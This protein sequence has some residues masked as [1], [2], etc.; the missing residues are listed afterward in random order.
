MG[1]HAFCAILDCAVEY[2]AKATPMPRI[3]IALLTSL[4][5]AAFAC[6]ES[7]RETPPPSKVDSESAPGISEKD[8]IGDG[9]VYFDLNRNGLRDRNEG[10]VANAIVFFEDGKFSRADAR[11]FYEMDIPE[12]GGI[13]WVRGQDDLDPG[14][15]WI[16]AES[17]T[18]E[19]LDIGVRRVTGSGEFSFVVGSD[20][21]AGIAEMSPADQL[22]GL[23]Q[24]A[25]VD[26]KP[27]FV[28]ITG[29]ITQSNQPEHFDTVIEAAAT[30]DVPYVP[31]PGNHDWYDGGAAYRSHFGPPT[32]S[33]DSGGMH[34][35]VLNDASSLTRRMSFLAMDL[36]L[37][38]DQRKVAVLMHAPPT[39]ELRLALEEHEIDL[40]LTGHLHANRVFQHDT[41]VE[42]NTQPLVMG[43]I[44]LSPAGFRHFRMSEAGELSIESRTTVNRGVFSFVSPG[45]AQVFA[46]CSAKVVVAVEPG[47]AISR[48][49]ATVGDLG[50]VLLD[51]AG[52]WDYSSATLETLCTFGDYQ[53]TATVEHAD[54]TAESIGATLTIGAA[55]STA[56]GGEWLMFQGGAGHTGSVAP[57]L[58]TPLQ[59]EWV[60]TVGAHIHGGSP[61]VSNNRVFISVSD[62]GDGLMGGVVALDLLS[63]AIL[64]EHRVAFSVRN[65]PAVSANRVFFVSNDGTLHAVDVLTGNSLWTYE[66]ATH[67]PAAQRSLYCAP[68][69]VDGIVYVGGRHEFVAIDALS[70]E[71]V[72]T[73]EP[74]SDFEVFSSHASA[75]VTDLAVLIPFNRRDGLFAF[76]RALGTQLWHAPSY[77]VQGAHA[78]PV[79]DGDQIYV[80]NELTQVRALGIDDFQ[81]RWSM[82]LEE[83]T[84]GWGYL[85]V[86]TPVLQGT[87]LLVG[88]Q[89]GTLHAIDTASRTVMWSFDVDTSFVRATHYHGESAAIS[90]SPVVTGDIVWLPGQDGFLRALDLVTGAELWSSDLG[91]PMSSS[92]AVAGDLLIVASYDGS[93]RAMRTAIAE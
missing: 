1:K 67:V 7:D 42:Y 77:L 25:G 21:H 34:F 5:F 33:F 53:V 36:A 85:A 62:F 71:L 76:D 10:G 50:L 41:F 23:A 44:D 9:I 13:L 49:S 3:G 22:V 81:T 75:V 83:G 17:G 70:G 61:V 84:F 68:T 51:H 6:G 86:A 32:Y 74:M 59:T 39:E 64:W 89:R 93:V 37:I 56:V 52:G 47:R 30:I 87:T 60:A 20:T 72:W 16:E 46:P 2:L 63:G 19:R 92:P 26:P 91:V 35:V 40:L 88:T 66:L 55:G 4:A 27:Y 65:A 90:A 11:G 15:Y 48:V 78:S 57:R 79:V 28:T 80:V 73:V 43:G 58:E 54:G 18:D 8:S 29:D 14:P 82:T 38:S 31:V 69:I 45:D 24:V 12:R